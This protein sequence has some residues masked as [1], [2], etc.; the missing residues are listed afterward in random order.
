MK[1]MPLVFY[2]LGEREKAFSFAHKN[3]DITDAQMLETRL[4]QKHAF[5][6]SSDTDASHLTC[7]IGPLESPAD[8]S[9]TGCIRVSF[10][11]ASPSDCS[12]HKKIS[13]VTSQGETR[14][15]ARGV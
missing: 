6:P 2:H 7:R 14:Q 1:S 13:I 11:S 9:L 8:I 10:M 15:T 4:S 5:I 12:P 3:K